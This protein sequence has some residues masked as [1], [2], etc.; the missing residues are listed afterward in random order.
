MES[1]LGFLRVIWCGCCGKLALLGPL[2]F[3]PAGL[4]CCSSV[5]KAI[6]KEAIGVFFFNASIFA[7]VQ[8]HMW[9]YCLLSYNKQTRYDFVG[10]ERDLLG[11][12]CIIIWRC[13][14][15]DGAA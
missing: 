2:W 7:S 10:I 5:L 13:S 14:C 12:L 8:Q 15:A 4:F 6:K 9:W 3:D 11:V 1:I